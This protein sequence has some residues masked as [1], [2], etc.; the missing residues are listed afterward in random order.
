MLKGSVW[1]VVGN[2]P[3]IR[4]KSLSEMTG[5]EIYG[6]AEYLNPG[7]SIKDR[8]AKGIIGDAEMTGRLKPGGTIVEGTAGNTGIGLATLAAE[9]GYHCIISMPDNQAT[10]KYDLIRVL[11][12]DLRLVPPCPFKNEN[13][14]YH[15]AKKI[16]E[17][18]P[19][20][21]WANQFENE[22]NGRFHFE[23]TGPEIWEQMEG[24]LDYLTLAVGTGGTFGGCSSFL[25]S[26]DP[27]IK[28]V[29]VDPPG[30]GLYKYI[31][32]GEIST[33]GG[34]ITEGIGI[35]RITA[36]F[37]LGQADDALRFEDQSM[38]DMLYHLASEDGLVVGTSAALNARA[39][40]EI[41][42]KNR[43]SGKRIVTFLCDSG[44]RYMSRLFNKD[45]LKEKGLRP[46]PL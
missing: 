37:A 38:I 30:S 1:D 19:D 34:S 12:A 17:D 25:K 10:E 29:V 41:A 2:T 6:K 36:N 28:I 45:W 9:R 44:T 26:K 35:M 46:K 4:I 15:Q 21:I 7:G 39:A 5:C 11:G 8:A 23:T 24:R 43:G 32:T 22:A 14:F 42:M 31:T 27:N 3:L 16:A 13:H 33:E 18:T 40:Y 20:A